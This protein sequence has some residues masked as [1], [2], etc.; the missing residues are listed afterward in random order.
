MKDKKILLL[1]SLRIYGGGEY[2]TLTLAKYLQKNGYSVIVSCPEDSL[3]Y[4]KCKDNRIK[5]ICLDYPKTGNGN[6]RRIIS[7]IKKIIKDNNVQ[8]VHSSTNFDRTAGAFATIRTNAVHAA[9]VHS[10][11]SV[12]RN[13]THLI[14]NKYYIKHFIAS[15]EKIKELLIDKDN[16]SPDKITSI[17]L[18]INPVEFKRNELLR[19]RTRNNMNIKEDE[20]VIGNVG[21]LVHFKGQENLIRAF[22]LL[23]KKFPDTKLI[24]TGSGELELRLKELCE[25]IKVKDKVIFTGFKENL[26]EIYSVFDIYVHNSLPGM[27]ELFPFAILYAMAQ[28]LPVIATNTGEIPRMVID[29]V[30]GYL[31]DE[32]NPELISQRIGILINDKDKRH[33]FGINGLKFLNEKFNEDIMGHA[34]TDIYDKITL[35]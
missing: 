23:N 31:C 14:R 18:G 30:N 7:E 17:N 19:S 29:G 28:S 24:I 15:G 6:L 22:S 11:Y 20:I 12:Q 8:I 25:E 26:L 9:S 10:F 35:K 2:F 3:L 21:R 27:E 33:S 1:N 5:L 4:K 34:I 32:S 16:I 13:L